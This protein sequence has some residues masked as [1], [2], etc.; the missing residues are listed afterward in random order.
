MI[1]EKEAS[2]D[3]LSKTD[4]IGASDTEIIDS[5]L[6]SETKYV[7]WFVYIEG[8]SKSQAFE[9]LAVERDSVATFTIYALVGDMIAYNRDVTSDGTSMSL[10][11]TNNEISTITVKVKRLIT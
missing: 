5:I 2:K 10:S 8:N 1:L 4:T 11:I 9:I 3:F 7:K 6:L